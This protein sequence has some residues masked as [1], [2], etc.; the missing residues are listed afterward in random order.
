MNKLT[1]ACT[2]FLSAFLIFIIQPVLAK[3]LLPSFGGSV[4]V[5][6]VCMLFFQSG[7]LLGYT[8]AY[9]LSKHAFKI[10]VAIHCCMLAV[11]FYFI[12]N[13]LPSSLSDSQ[14]WP[15]LILMQLLTVKILLPFALLSS[16]SPLLQSWYCQIKHTDFPYYFYSISN[17]GSL[18]GLFCFPFVLEWW[19]RLDQQ[20]AGW[21][22]LYFVFAALCTLSALPLLG[23]K[24]TYTEKI[25]K[26]AIAPSPKTISLWLGLSALGS[27]FML[28]STNFILQ[29]IINMPL[30]WILPLSL[31]LVTFI[32]TF[33]KPKQYNR[34]FW[35]LSIG[36]WTLLLA[37]SIHSNAIVNNLLNGVAVVLALLYSACMLCHG[38]LIQRKPSTQY[39]TLFYLIMS[40]GGVLG[41]LFVTLGGYWLFNDLWDFYIP[42]ALIAGISIY[43]L[44]K[45][46][47][48]TRHKWDLFMLSG[49]VLSLC[50]FGLA[51]LEPM[52]NNSIHLVTKTRSA[53]G[54]IKVEDA[55]STTTNHTSD[56]RRL[57][58]GPII[59][60]KQFLAPLKKNFATTYYGKESGIGYSVDFL[61]KKN[62]RLK[63]AV[64]GLGAGTIAALCNN[65]DQVDFYE[66]DAKM[67]S[68]SQTYFSFIQDS[69]AK[70]NFYLGDGR[71][72][73]Q[74][75]LNQL[76]SQQYDLI[77]LD[78]F[79]GDSIPFH[80]I[81][82]EALELY[83]KHLKPKGI[84]AFHTSNKF[85]DLKPITQ[86]LAQNKL[87]WHFWVETV[88]EPKIGTLA[89]T[90]ALMSRDP[91]L[92]PW[93]YQ[94]DQSIS[95][96]QKAQKPLL[97]T[98]NHNSML[99]LIVWSP[100]DN[101]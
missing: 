53:Y 63:I 7:L 15:P 14:Q 97:W 86:A 27:A 84:I 20:M 30:I 38:E 96:S 44:L 90:W 72:E 4:F 98:D 51:H 85:I 11:S 8:Y 9:L 39:L 22:I 48:T 33:A 69:K 36:I 83:Q 13:T 78:A 17:A 77:A 41:G 99:P 59:H 34:N 68:I 32:V 6:V 76:G 89:S 50:I 100:P 81:T 49:S 88:G 5:W 26:Q 29:N 23:L 79:N 75:L 67:L 71:I 47:F 95:L 54:M 43:I 12:D 57:V 61:R 73:M 94:I 35:A 42:F 1:Y 21:N 18:L 91:E 64:I 93:L 24:S 37:W 92:A 2:T 82:V 3:S 70:A 40:L 60:G 87:L 66:I 65:K 56:H 45:Q 58:H 62:A 74:K 52:F 19:L 16:T 28:A 80:L 25:D 31:Y 55:R 101:S 10:Q 46:Y